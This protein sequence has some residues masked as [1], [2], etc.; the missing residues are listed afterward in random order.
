[1]VVSWLL[2]LLPHRVSSV[3]FI[4]P[5]TFLLFLPNVCINFVYARPRMFDLRAWVIHYFAKREMNTAI[6]LSRHFYW[7]QNDLWIE[8]LDDS[9]KVMVCLAGQ[10][11]IVPSG[12]VKQYLSQ[13][14]CSSTESRLQLLYMEDFHHAG[15]IF[16]LS[17]IK[18]I[19]RGLRAHV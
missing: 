6:T 5:V 19:V 13:H 16:N 1:M 8:D 11:M 3:S 9:M 10:D 7:Y 2:R 12:A 14:A 17:A 18:T 15:F 4:D